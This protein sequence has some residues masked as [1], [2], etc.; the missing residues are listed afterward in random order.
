MKRH[1]IICI[2]LG[3][4]AVSCEKHD[5]LKRGAAE[6]DAMIQKDQAA[7][8]L[9]EQNIRS[10]GGREALE[11][12][13]GQAEMLRV[14]VDALRQQNDSRRKKWAAI[15]AE[16]SKLKPAAEAFKASQPQ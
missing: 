9:Y 11:K 13:R 1:L 8:D 16:F 5:V 14:R 12:L 6:L 7:I 3:F 15:D 2:A 4:S 10:L